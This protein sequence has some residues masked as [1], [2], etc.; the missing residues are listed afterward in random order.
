MFYPHVKQTFLS[1]IINEQTW[2]GVNDKEQE[3]TWRWVDGTP[4]TLM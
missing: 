1:T 4:P 3:G 2:I